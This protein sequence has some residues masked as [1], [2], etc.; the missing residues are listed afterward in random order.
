M[1]GQ[2][3]EIVAGADPRDELVRELSLSDAILLVVACVVG[4]GIFFTPGRVAALVP[5]PSWM[6]C[7]WLLG[8]ALSLAGALANAE[9]GGMFPRAGGNYVYLREG[10]HPVAG[11]LVGWL[12]FFAI[13]ARPRCISRIFKN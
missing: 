5:D 10:V 2:S 9:L 3:E 11:F 1:Q 8:G 13:F 6:L 4:A 7:A 12:S